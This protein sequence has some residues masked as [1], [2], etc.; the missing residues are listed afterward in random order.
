MKNPKAAV[1][2]ITACGERVGGMVLG[3][4]TLG[5]AAVLD[6]A[7]S[8]FAGGLAPGEEPTPEDVLLIVF[9]LAHSAQESM[10]LLRDGTFGD[11]VMAFA[12]TVPLAAAQGLMGA[13]T[14]ILKR[15]ADVSPQGGAGKNPPA[16]GTGCSPSSPGRPR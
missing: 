1:E 2:A 6:K 3:E 11:A 9:V 13:V 14:R 5:R 4:L 16:A 12:D 10:A 8:R 7:G 15:V